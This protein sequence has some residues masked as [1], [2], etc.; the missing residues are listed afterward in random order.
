MRSA[1][2]G[3]PDERRRKQ[4]EANARYS[5]THSFAERKQR[6]IAKLGE[7]EYRRLIADKAARWAAAHRDTVNER[8]RKKRAANPQHVRD[9]A[10][11][12]RQRRTETQKHM[13]RAAQRAFYRKNRDRI[14]EERRTAYASDSEYRSRVRAGQQSYYAKNS[15]SIKQITSRWQKAN[16]DKFKRIST[17]ATHKRRATIREAA[18]AFTISQVMSRV[19]YFGWRCRYCLL[20]LTDKTLTLD[21]QIPLCR[22]GSNWPSNIVPAC[23]HCNKSKNKK[24]FKEYQ[25]IIGSGI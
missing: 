7:Q 23:S 18:G 15:D 22:G 19:E 2:A 12:H 11:R 21:H 24:T 3:T 10:K 6:E 16:P 17:K 5:A 13:V 8:A 1:Y 25:A 20:R 9:I 4:R 14:C